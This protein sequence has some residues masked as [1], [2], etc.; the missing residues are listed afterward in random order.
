MEKKYIE[1]KLQKADDGKITIVASD[2]TLD[3]MGEV[4][5][6]ESWDIT[7]F[8]KNP[9]LLVDHDYKVEKIVGR[10][11]NL[12]LKK[13]ERQMVFNPD[14]HGLTQL[15]K[16]VEAMVTNDYAP[17]VSVGFL[18]HG[19]KKDGERVMNELLEISFVS[20][21]A[22]P[23]ALALAMKSINDAQVKEVEAWVAKDLEPVT[24]TGSDTDTEVKMVSM[25]K[26]FAD[27]LSKSM[28]ELADLK[29]GRVL[30][31]KTR[32]KLSDCSTALKQAFTSIEDLL[33]MDA[34]NEGEQGKS[35]EPA[36]EHEVTAPAKVPSS[37][38]RALQDINKMSNLVLQQVKKPSLS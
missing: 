9:V 23:N 37:V 32:A 11:L 31:K 1:L 18:P 36:K 22:N 7:N 10:A 5:P 4:V 2:E 28:D 8:K 30:S 20:V 24:D 15:S 34:Q 26:E 35:R 38:V 16:E 6:F 29:E 3:R 12:Q 27:T 33:T 25:T 17:A 14:F 13:D 19:P 21:P